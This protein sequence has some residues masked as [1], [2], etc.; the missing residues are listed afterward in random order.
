MKTLSFIVITLFIFSCSK[1][2]FDIKRYPSNYGGESYG[3]S[4]DY[5]EKWVQD[6]MSEKTRIGAGTVEFPAGLTG[7]EVADLWHLNEGSEF[8]PLKWMFHL[9]SVNSNLKGTKFLDKLDEKFGVIYDSY[10][11]QYGYPVPWIGVTAAWT[12]THPTESDVLVEANEPVKFLKWVDAKPK[13]AVSGVNCSFCHTSEVQYQSPYGQENRKMILDG[14]PANMYIRGYFRDMVAS[15]I[16]T[17][18][19]PEMLTEFIDNNLGQTPGTSKK[20]AKQFS[21][22]FRIELGLDKER[23]YGRWFD[24]AIRGLYRR[25]SPDNYQNS[26]LK[27]LQDALFQRRDVVKKYLVKLVELTYDLKGN[28]VPQELIFRLERLAITVGSDPDLPVTP[29]GYT[30]TDAFGR[31]GN[32]VARMNDPIE[33]TATTS[34]PH[35]WSTKYKSLF[36]WNAN[37]NSV[38]N[39]NIGQSFGLGAVLTGPEIEDSASLTEELKHNATTNLHNLAKIEKLLYKIQVPKFD[40]IF[41]QHTMED[42]TTLQN[43]C[44]TFAN[45]CMGCHQ[46]DQRVGPMGKLV[47]DN[48]IPHRVINTDS[49]YSELQ[50]K[51][52][53]GVPLKDALF[54]FVNAVKKRYYSRFDI[55]EREQRDWQNKDFRG[56]EYFRDTFVGENSHDPNGPS[57]YL[58]I[59]KR[60]A[61]YPARS[62]A[63]AWATAPYM[64]NGSIPTVADIL[65]PENERPKIFFVGSN[66]YDNENMGFKSGLDSLPIPKEE[67]EREFQA[68]YSQKALVSKMNSGTYDSSLLEFACD[69]FPAR[70]FNSSHKGNSN[71]GHSGEKFGTN[72]PSQE[73]QD[74]IYFLKY[75]KPHIE[76]SWN[77]PPL[78]HVKREAGKVECVLY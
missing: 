49:W 10:S 52:V 31:I 36:H 58:N 27:A 60:Q 29:E 54:G 76:Y 32:L 21:K 75:V 66:E 3:Q 74:L 6:L 28:P 13:F 71:K 78:Y 43:G 63:G 16:K 37:T 42:R 22:Q 46:T 18:L 9:E 4:V 44:N 7:K 14:A 65:K 70:C 45:K 56:P 53:D 68:Q 17:M 30:R 8:Y 51:P 1:N 20:I 62:L 2:N 33:L 57:A 67:I 38:M 15:T 5:S 23:F 72:L 64:H 34:V 61:G 47:H 12:E 41:P 77:S 26:V 24:N 39:R 40:S 55:S 11:V 19:T 25:V 59:D 69:K 50:K 73:K 35:M 48:M